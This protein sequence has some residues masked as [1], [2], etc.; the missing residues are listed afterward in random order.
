MNING[1]T[2]IENITD[3]PTWFY[4]ACMIMLAFLVFVLMSSILSLLV[5]K[6][7]KKLQI[8]LS[9]TGIIIVSALLGTEKMYDPLNIKVPTDEYIVCATSGADI[10]EILE[11]YKILEYDNNLITIRS[12]ESSDN[13]NDALKIVYVILA[14]IC[15]DRLIRYMDETAHHDKK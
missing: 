5:S 14:A 9:V 15:I 13:L 7:G 4:F 6:N 11:K 10:N 2:V 3:L 8:V 12:I 1:V